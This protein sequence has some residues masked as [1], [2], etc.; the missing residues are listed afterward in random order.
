MSKYPKE[1]NKA[2]K[3][4]CLSWGLS[5]AMLLLAV[6]YRQV[7]VSAIEQLNKKSSGT[8]IKCRN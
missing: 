3:L 7:A 1:M 4:A 5:A 2:V 8:E 6:S